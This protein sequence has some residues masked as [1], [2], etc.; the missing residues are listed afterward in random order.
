MLLNSILDQVKLIQPCSK[1]GLGSSAQRFFFHGSH[2]EPKP[3][4]TWFISATQQ[5]SKAALCGW[6]I[7]AWPSV[8]KSAWRNPSNPLTEATNSFACGKMRSPLPSS[9][10]PFGKQHTKINPTG[11]TVDGVVDG[12]WGEGPNTSKLHRVSIFPNSHDLEVAPF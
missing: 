6:P 11:L 5:L 4:N 2:G 7:T 1:W 3:W 12:C 8:K 9:K 10:A